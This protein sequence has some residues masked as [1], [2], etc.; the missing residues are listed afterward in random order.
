MS[1][2]DD[3]LLRDAYLNSMEK[4]FEQ[5]MVNTRKNAAPR[6]NP[7]LT[8]KMLD[9]NDILGRLVTMVAIMEACIYTL[10]KDDKYHDTKVI[11]MVV[12]KGLDRV[13]ASV[14][15]PEEPTSDVDSQQMGTKGTGNK[16]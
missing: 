4:L 10:L 5:A 15:P 13:F 1:A 2:I 8:V 11:R 16:P 6:A 3:V 7:T 9:E 14:L 12:M